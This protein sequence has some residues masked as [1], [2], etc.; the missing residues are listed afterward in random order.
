MADS[1][2]FC[3]FQVHTGEEVVNRL[4]ALGEVFL[5]LGV[6]YTAVALSLSL[7]EGILPAL[8]VLLAGIATTYL[9]TRRPDGHGG[10]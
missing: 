3:G 9:G 5:G 2:D 7:P 10:P 1:T 8:F 4:Q 6:V